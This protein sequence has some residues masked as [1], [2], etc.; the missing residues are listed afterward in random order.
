V[1]YDLTEHRVSAQDAAL[2]VE[3]NSERAL[4]HGVDDLLNDP[5]RRERMAQYG[6]DRVRDK[7]VWQHSVPHLLAAYDT[8]FAPSRVAAKRA[9]WRVKGAPAWNEGQTD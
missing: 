3:P 9:D 4:A 8:I 6:A 1:S 2:Y 5:G 7:L